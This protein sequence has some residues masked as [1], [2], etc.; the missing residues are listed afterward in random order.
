MDSVRLALIQLRTVDSKAANLNRARELVVEAAAQGAKIVVLPECFN[1]PYGIDMYEE[2]AE[3]IDLVHP[4]ETIE[5][6]SAL[7]KDAGIYLVGGSILE[8]LPKDDGSTAIFNTSTVW[9]PSGALIAKHRKLHL[10]AIDYKGR[11]FD[12]ADVL[13]AGDSM[14]EFATPWG[15]FG[16]AVCYDVRFPELAMAA[17]RNGCVGMV[18]PCAFNTRIGPPHWDLL[19]RTRAVDNLMFV[20]GCNPALNEDAEYHAYGHSTIVD[21]LASVVATSDTAEAIVA[22]DLDLSLIRAARTSIP[23][24]AH[25]RADVYADVRRRPAAEDLGSLPRSPASD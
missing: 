7:A 16:V 25:K 15:R 22:A 17:A 23:I 20:A 24:Y 19:L 21:P 1:M 11:K 4:S 12:E 6:L 5:M 8:R 9:D 14:T 3:E 10:F 2:Y 18:Y 13:D